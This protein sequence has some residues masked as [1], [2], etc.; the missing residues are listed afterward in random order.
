MMVLEK[1]QK[2][3]HQNILKV[4]KVEV[5]IMQNGPFHNNNKK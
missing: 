4:L 5:H 1:L 2:Y 3:W